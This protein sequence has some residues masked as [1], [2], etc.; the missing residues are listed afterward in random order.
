MSSQPPAQL[1]GIILAGGE[2]R[3]MGQDKAFLEVDG[4]LLM[5][6]VLGAIRALADD[7][8]IVTNAP[9]KYTAFPARLARDAYPG[10]G[11]LGGIYTGLLMAEHPCG[12]VVACDMPFL[13]V[14]LLCYMAGLVWQYD[15]VM[16]YLGDEELPTDVRTTRDTARARDLHPL[17]AI[18]CKQCLGPIEKAIRRGDLRTIAFLPEVNVRFVGR[19]EIDRF[20][21]EHRSFFNANTPEELGYARELSRSHS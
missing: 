18:Y 5:D 20:D 3:R 1:S 7:V 13:N 4:Q 19:R 15:V 21:P 16:P 8:I 9:E 10:T 12:L 17:H 11:A 6:R 2:S 14:D